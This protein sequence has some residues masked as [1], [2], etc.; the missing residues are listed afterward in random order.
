[1]T[2]GGV[3]ILLH[4]F[5]ASAFE[6]DEWSVLRPSGFAPPPRE[7]SPGTRWIEAEWAP[8]PVWT[9]Q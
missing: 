7:K 3:E 5:S 6:G 4:A 2:Y 9:W 1:M 8:E